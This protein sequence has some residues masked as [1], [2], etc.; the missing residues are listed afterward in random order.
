[1]PEEIIGEVIVGAIEIV[2]L[3]DS[4]NPKKGCGCLFLILL[5]CLMSFGIYWLVNY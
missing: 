4:D 1:M 2:A 5:F 3:S